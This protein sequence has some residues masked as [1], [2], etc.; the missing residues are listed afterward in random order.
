MLSAA[1]IISLII[2]WVLGFITYF[3]VRTGYKLLI[4]VLEETQKEP[5][6]DSDQLH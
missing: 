6:A 5:L 2:G 3:A 4:E 1:I